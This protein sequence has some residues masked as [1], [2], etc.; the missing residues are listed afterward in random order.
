M[1][2]TNAFIKVENMK[3]KLTLILC[4]YFCSTQLHAQEKMQ[5]LQFIIEDYIYKRDPNPDVVKLLKL[6]KEA[7]IPESK[8]LMGTWVGVE[9]NYI[10]KYSDGLS[11]ELKPKQSVLSCGLTSLENEA[12]PIFEETEKKHGCFFG[13]YGD[14]RAYLEGFDIKLTSKEQKNKRH[15]EESKENTGK[16][17]NINVKMSTKM[18]KDTVQ[19]G[20]NKNIFVNLQESLCVDFGAEYSGKHVRLYS[21]RYICF[22][23]KNNYL[24]YVKISEL[25]GSRKI[26]NVGY[27]F[28]KIS[29]VDMGFLTNLSFGIKNFFT[30]FRLFGNSEQY[31][32]NGGGQGWKILTD[33][34]LRK[35]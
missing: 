20:I 11:E 28:N 3:L 35:Y 14:D 16:V 5:D 8:E 19:A 23:Q 26:S 2:Y 7:T 27:F 22:T 13:S 32:R 9:L 30:N 6:Y 18:N 15:G 17:E 21:Y 31:Y 10:G 1:N 25:W 29:K 12:G 33:D 4:I 34:D 24:I